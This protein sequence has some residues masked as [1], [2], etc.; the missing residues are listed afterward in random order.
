M[1]TRKQGNQEPTGKPHDPDFIGAEIAMR[2]AAESARRRAIETSGSVVVFKNGKIV[3]N[4][5]STEFSVEDSLN[6]PSV[7]FQSITFSD[8]T[9]IP[10]GSTD[11]VVLVGPN[12]A[13]KSVALREL[14]E[15]FGNPIETS[16]IKSAPTL[17][18]GTRE[19]FGAFVKGHMQVRTQG[20]SRIYS[21][22]GFSFSTDI[23]AEGMWPDGFSTFRSLFCLRI[24]TEMRISGSNPVAP[25]NVLDEP[26]SHPIHRLYS[27]DELERR[28]S[29]YFRR[30]FGED[31]VVFHAA[32][33]QI[34]LFV[35]QRPH[36]ALRE[37]RTSRSYSERLRNSTVPLTDQGD[38]MRSFA[39]VVLHLLAPTTPSILLLDEPEAFLHPPQARLLGE[40]VATEKS[41]RAQLF[42]ATHS[43][44]VLHGLMTVAPDHLRILRM[45]REGNVN[46]IRELDKQL[47]KTISSDALMKYSSVMSGVFHE[48]V[49]I[50]EGDSDCLFYSTLLDLPAVHGERQPDVLFIHANGKDRMAALAKV[51]VD[52]GVPVDVIADM[53]VLKDTA[54]VRRIVESLGG[55]WES[56]KPMATAVKA[57]VEEQKPSLSL[58]EIKKEVEDVLQESPPKDD[59]PRK[60]QARVDAIFRKASPWDTLKKAGESALPPGETTKQFRSLRATCKDLGLWITPVGELEG[61][62]KAVGGHGASWVQQVI[63]QKDLVASPELEHAR[64]FVREIWATRNQ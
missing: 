41:S 27:D 3:Q 48:R 11:V 55:H 40:I 24:P 50:C 7:T 53:D 42:V 13:G 4:R 37:Q 62:C 28:I 56:V 30:A 19:A 35:G 47:V 59:T 10:L 49:F 33:N 60:L 1:T 5:M 29:G 64:Q 12:N 17:K 32:G 38:G 8:G 31:L 54:T 16:V 43:T 51:L 2:R 36:L 58:D 45:Q 18:T 52:L 21:G 63:E 20:S 57:A 34:P 46:R 61:F 15:H 6:T 22:P 9:T 25:I 23:E 26:P 14:E 44:D 39:S